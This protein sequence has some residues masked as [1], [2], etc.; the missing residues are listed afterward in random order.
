MTEVMTFALPEKISGLIYK[1]LRALLGDRKKI[2]PATF[3]A[4][5][6]T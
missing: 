6:M 5:L 3:A 4:G 2:S 1:A